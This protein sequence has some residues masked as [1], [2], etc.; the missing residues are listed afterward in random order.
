MLVEQVGVSRSRDERTL[1][2]Q[3]PVMGLKASGESG[4]DEEQKQQTSHGSN[5]A[6]SEILPLVADL[7]YCERK[8]PSQNADPRL[9]FF[10]IFCLHSLAQ[11]NVLVS[12]HSG[13]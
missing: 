12:V 4:D 13:E 7:T 1:V 6:A 2:A 8:V 10:A 3:P 11:D 9:A 5:L